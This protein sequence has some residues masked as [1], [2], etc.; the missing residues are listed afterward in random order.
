MGMTMT[1][2]ILANHAGLDLVKLGQFIK[3]Q[4]DLVMGNDATF[5]VSLNEY[6]K[7]GFNKVFNKKKV[8]LV[9]DHFKDIKAAENCRLCREFAKELD[10]KYFY[11]TGHVGREHVLLPEQGFVAPGEMGIHIPV[12]MEH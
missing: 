8:I 1:E 4:L 3:A 2:K 7:A 12:I 11:D 10:L 6:R 5:P 9:M